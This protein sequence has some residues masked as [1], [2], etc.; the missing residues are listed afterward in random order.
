MAEQMRLGLVGYG[1]IGSTLGGGLRGQGLASIVAYDRYAFD[2]P[3]S[4]LIQRRAE[5]AG[6]LLVRDAESAAD[7]LAMAV[8]VRR[9]TR[10]VAVDVLLGVLILAFAVLGRFG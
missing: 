7:P 10:L 3:Y 4:G 2:G 1:E 8:A 5:E 6:V 9:L